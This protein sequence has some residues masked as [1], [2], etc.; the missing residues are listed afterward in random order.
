M[1]L[2]DLHIWTYIFFDSLRF[3][4]VWMNAPQLAPWWGRVVLLNSFRKPANAKMLFFL[5]LITLLSL[6]SNYG[7]DG[8]F[9]IYEGNYIRSHNGFMISLVA[10]NW[11][12]AENQSVLLDNASYVITR[13]GT[14]ISNITLNE[15]ERYHITLYEGGRIKKRLLKVRLKELGYALDGNR[16]AFYAETDVSSVNYILPDPPKIVSVNIS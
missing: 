7:G 10:I 3:I 6:A 4:P 5:L 2:H 14:W 8:S 11:H 15:G 12:Y 13:D 1:I 16:T 9:E